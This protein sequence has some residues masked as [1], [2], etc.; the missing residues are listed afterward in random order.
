MVR[1][2][3]KLRLA[4]VSILAGILMMSAGCG[5]AAKAG[6]KALIGV[7]ADTIVLDPV[8]RLQD[9]DVVKLSG[10]TTDVRA[11]CPQAVLNSVERSTRDALR[12][13]EVLA[14]SGDGKALRLAVECRFY[15]K[16]SIVG[17]VGRLDVIARI[18]DEATGQSL[19]RI[20]VEGVTD[21]PVHTEMEDMAKKV[22][23]E[24]IDFLEKSR[25]GSSR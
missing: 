5:M 20:Y 22:G 17:N 10:V 14:A 12:E 9:Y 23:E 21:S 7:E 24:I 4:T 3:W 15:K 2:S 11:I 8:P 13:S 6:V 25:A 19:G 18:T 16:K 1:F